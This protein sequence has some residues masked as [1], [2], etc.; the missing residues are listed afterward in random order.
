L[1]VF[2]SRLRLDETI[3]TK[4]GE[5]LRYG[6]LPLIMIESAGAAGAFKRAFDA[7]FTGGENLSLGVDR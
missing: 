3:E 6:R 7:R 1:I 2:P 5:L 4:A